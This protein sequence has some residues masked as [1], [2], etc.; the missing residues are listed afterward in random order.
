M[1]N[2]SFDVCGINATN[3]GLGHNEDLQKSIMAN[4]EVG[5]AED[6]ETDDMFKD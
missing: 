5:N 4:V 3:P 2:P 1:V 6:D